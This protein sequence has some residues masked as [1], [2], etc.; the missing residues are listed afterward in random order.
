MCNLD[1][2][3]FNTIGNNW[4]LCS[5]ETW[6]DFHDW[7]GKIHNHNP[8]SENCALKLRTELFKFS[9]NSEGVESS[10]MFAL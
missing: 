9:K 7:N 5:V 4:N 1:S 6:S 10:L 8:S 2:F 3:Q